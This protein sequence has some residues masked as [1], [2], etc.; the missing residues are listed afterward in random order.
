MKVRV[1]KWGNSLAVRIPKSFATETRIEQDT[2]VDLSIVEGKLV[3]SPA[4]VPEV[5]LEQLLERVTP[6]NCPGEFETGPA[7]G[8]EIW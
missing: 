7:V 2:E 4:T 3:I 1:Q 8:A 6:E 5:T